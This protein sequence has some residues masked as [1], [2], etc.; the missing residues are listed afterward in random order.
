MVIS[1]WKEFKKNIN[2][3][4][5]EVYPGV[6]FKKLTRQQIADLSKKS[7][8][9]VVAFKKIAPDFNVGE[10]DKEILCLAKEYKKIKNEK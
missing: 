3:Q 6:N 9:A 1:T 5:G 7:A 4:S 10:L 8:K 2:T